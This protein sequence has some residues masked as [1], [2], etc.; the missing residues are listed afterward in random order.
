MNQPIRGH[1]FLNE[2]IKALGLEEQCLNRVVIVADV[3]DVVKIYYRGYLPLDKMPK[4]MGCIKLIEADAE[5]VETRDGPIVVVKGPT[6]PRK[7]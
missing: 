2:L 3:E 7:E 1:V 6:D 5:V 4:L